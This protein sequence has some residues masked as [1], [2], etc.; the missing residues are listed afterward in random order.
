M[1]VMTGALLYSFGRR[2]RH[3]ELTEEMQIPL[4]PIPT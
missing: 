2:E 4:R 1:S 3:S